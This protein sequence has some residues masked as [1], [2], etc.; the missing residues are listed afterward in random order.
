VKRRNSCSARARAARLA[1]LGLLFGAIA[2]AA[3]AGDIKQSFGKGRIAPAAVDRMPAPADP[4]AAP[5]DL[6]GLAPVDGYG[7]AAE[8]GLSSRD[9]CRTLT[10]EQ[11]AGCLD[12]VARRRSGGREPPELPL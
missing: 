9:E 5:S 1:A 11:R 8:L 2:G 12:Y 4:A 10:L 6:F 7:R 3:A